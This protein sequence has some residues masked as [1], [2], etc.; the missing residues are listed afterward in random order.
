MHAAT[1]S[2]DP[3]LI[4]E[5]RWLHYMSEKIDFKIK[6]KKIN[7]IKKIKNGKD[8]TIISSSYS[9]FEIL[10]LYN[11]LKK[12]NISIDPLDIIVL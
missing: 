3:V 9:T 5:H 7:S 6:P 12:N 1:K 10:K 2:S 4:I 8:L 11:D